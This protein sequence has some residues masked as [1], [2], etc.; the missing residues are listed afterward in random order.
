MDLAAV[1]H[2]AGSYRRA[3]TERSRVRG[4]TQDGDEPVDDSRYA[5]S[6]VSQFNFEMKRPSISRVN[7]PY[8]S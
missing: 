1:R 8:T 6:H 3:V 7:P 4:F 5:T 2:A